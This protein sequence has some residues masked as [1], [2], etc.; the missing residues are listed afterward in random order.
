[1]IAQCCENAKRLF[2]E[3]TAQQ[4]VRGRIDSLYGPSN[5]KLRAGILTVLRGVPVPPSRAN[6]GD[7]RRAMLDLFGATGECIAEED[8]ELERI[9]AAC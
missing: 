3:Y 4:R 1:M 5:A 6:W 8:A 7:F 9:A 2:L